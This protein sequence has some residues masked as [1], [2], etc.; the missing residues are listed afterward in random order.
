[1]MAMSIYCIKINL[2]I[3]FS[4]A[5]DIITLSHGGKHNLIKDIVHFKKVLMYNIYITIDKEEKERNFLHNVG[6]YKRLA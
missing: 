5:T 1:M 2:N 4:K 3:F 6:I